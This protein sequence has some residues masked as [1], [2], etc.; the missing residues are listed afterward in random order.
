MSQILERHHITL[1][2]KPA[3]YFT[4]GDTGSA[5]QPIHLYHANAYPFGSYQNFLSQLKGENAI[6]GLGHRATW[7]NNREP[8]HQLSWRHYGDDLIEFLE[9][10]DCGPVI[11]MGHSMG[12]VTTVFAAAKRPDLFKA[13]VLIDPVFIPTSMWL[14][15]RSMW[16]FS[17]SKNIMAKIAEKRP[18]RWDSRHE[19][20]EFHGSK[21]AFS[22]FGS[23]AMNDFSNHAIEAD[24]DEFGLAFPR[25][26]E[27]HIYRTVPYVWRSLKSLSMPVLGIRGGDSNVLGPTAMKKW[28]KLQ[29]KHQLVTLAGVGHLA[30]QEGAEQ[31]ADV[32]NKFLADLK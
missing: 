18:N 24:G 7:A 1:K 5:Q 3:H 13:L 20:A 28:Q 29:P 31:C 27:A 11:G 17:K 25:E 26:W 2:N 9:Q 16:S 32:I 23:E 10:Q 30:P 8:D 15:A 12:A 6:F 4:L 22:K 14:L 19:A 21:R